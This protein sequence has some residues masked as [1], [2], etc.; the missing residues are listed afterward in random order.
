MA[1][2]CAGT[3]ANCPNDNVSPAGTPCGSSFGICSV[4]LKDVCDGKSYSCNSAPSA[5]VFYWDA[6]NVLSFDSYTCSDGDIEGRLAAMNNVELHNFDIGLKTTPSDPFSAYDLVV[7]GNAIWTSGACRSGDT[8]GEI[9]V[10]GNF[11][12]PAYLQELRDSSVY[13]SKLNFQQAQ[14]YYVT[15]SQRIALMPVNAKVTVQYGGL[16][17]TCNNINDTMIIFQVSAYDFNTT[18]WYSTENCRYSAAY[19]MTLTG[20]GDIEIKGGQFPGIVERLVYNSPQAR[21]IVASTGVYANLLAPTS[22]YY[23]T[24]GV[25]YGKVIIGNVTLARQN[26]KPN[27]VDIVNS[28]ISNV[29]LRQVNPGDSAVV[30]A[31]LS[32]YVVG[33]QICIDTECRVIKSGV[34][35]D[36]DGDGVK[37]N[38]ILVTQPFNYAHPAGSRLMTIVTDAESP[39]RDASIPISDELPEGAIDGV[40]A[41]SASTL[42]AS[43]MLVAALSLL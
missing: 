4:V 21:S 10:G 22:T 7:G 12:A 6:F 11:T 41:S 39:L 2:Y 38:I 25:S 28:T 13:I 20:P 37:D 3:S 8:T 40:K 5:N 34:V 30:V 33:D 9:V 42:V 35:A 32:N 26:N 14:Q 1:E 27:C 43:A 36:V 16:K 31:S 24:T 29:N 17:V 18:N 19:I 23:Q 15:M